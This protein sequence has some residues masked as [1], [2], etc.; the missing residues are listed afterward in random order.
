MRKLAPALILVTLLPVALSASTRLT[1]LIK[2]DPSA[3]SSTPTSLFWPKASFP[4][5]YRIDPSAATMLPDGQPSIDRAFQKWASVPDSYVRFRADGVSAA[6]A[7]EDGV[8]S[9]SVSSDLFANSGFIAYT[10]TWFDNAGTLR[11]ADIQIDAS[12]AADMQKLDG[13]VEHEIGHLLGLDHSGVVSATMYPFV[14]PNGVA[15]LDMD[16]RIAIA[17]LYPG[18]GFAASTAVI[19]GSVSGSTG[20][21]FG[22]QVVAYDSTG[23]PVSSCLSKTDGSYELAGLPP[24]TYS[25]YVEPLDGP[26]SPG[27]LSGLWQ[28][29]ADK[30]FRTE[31]LASQTISVT[32]GGVYENVA[33]RGDSPTT[34]NPK[35]IGSFPPAGNAIQ[36]GSTAVSVSAGQT[37]AIAV[38]GDGMVGGMTEFRPLNPKVQ[39]VSEFQYGPNYVWATFKV[40]PD[41]QSGSVVLLVSSGNEEAALTGGLRV[42]GSAGGGGGRTRPVR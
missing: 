35:W 11:E 9:I 20:P 15:D 6:R 28:T 30:P 34:L 31:F 38:G 19:R 10:T 40:A 17:S 1:Y 4:I 8:N 12:A 22:A 13:L 32:S 16:D 42:T 36:L 24:G 26:V 39:R 3:T 25:L 33:L 7:G 5:P 29:A 14:S 23:A 37:I 18:D 27:N 41:I 21:I 2:P